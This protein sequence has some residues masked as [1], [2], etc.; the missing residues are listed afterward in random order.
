MYLSIHIIRI[1]T[2]IIDV[3]ICIIRIATWMKEIAIRVA[4][5]ATRIKVIAIQIVHSGGRMTDKANWL[6]NWGDFSCKSR[7]LMK[8]RMICV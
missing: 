1:T 7:E 6:S 4:E 2:C 3:V 8:E 5:V